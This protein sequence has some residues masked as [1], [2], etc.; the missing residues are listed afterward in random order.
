MGLV[1]LG[2]FHPS[3]VDSSLFGVIRPSMICICLRVCFV[4]LFTCGPLSAPHSSSTNVTHGRIC[5]VSHPV[6]R[7]AH[8]S[9]RCQTHFVELGEQKSAHSDAR[10]LFPFYIASKL[11]KEG[12]SR[13]PIYSS[14][15]AHIPADSTAPFC[16][17]SSKKP[18][19][20]TVF[21]S[22]AERGYGLH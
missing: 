16:F 1:F 2:F 6:C 19:D 9:R 11:V 7:S 14:V 17:T 12:Q 22:L 20:T 8:P 13:A 18:S 3:G 10:L 15:L 5:S 4:I 21:L